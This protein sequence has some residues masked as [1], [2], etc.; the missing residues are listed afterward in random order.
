MSD[1]D[2]FTTPIQTSAASTETMIEVTVHVPI[3][4]RGIQTCMVTLAASDSK[5]KTISS[6]AMTLV[7][8]QT[9]DID[10]DLIEHNV[11]VANRFAETAVIGHF[12]N[13]AT[14]RREA[15]FSAMIPPTG[16][17]TEFKIFYN[18]EEFSSKIKVPTASPSANFTINADM[19]HDATFDPDRPSLY[20]RSFSLHEVMSTS[21]EKMSLVKLHHDKNR[22]TG[23]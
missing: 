5:G 1:W 14:T 13:V 19:S 17:V 23:K 7:A 8:D 3:T 18:G 11:R 22:L 9:P 2:V 15:I 21:G 12:N 6:F 10:P 16:F 4:A 20:A